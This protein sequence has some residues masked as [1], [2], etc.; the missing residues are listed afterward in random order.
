MTE[1]NHATEPE[2]HMLKT[3]NPAASPLSV[4]RH[5][6]CIAVR[7]FY[8]RKH[9]HSAIFYRP[10]TAARSDKLNHYITTGGR[11]WHLQAGILRYNARVGPAARSRK[12]AGSIP[13]RVTEFFN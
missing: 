8:Q 1:Q 7:P 13:H 5:S 11:G 10:V 2:R 3:E 12:V 6:G 4:R 9:K